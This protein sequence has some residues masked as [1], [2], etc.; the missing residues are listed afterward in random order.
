MYFD[1]H[2]CEILLSEKG[3]C[4]CQMGEFAQI[5]P[6]AAGRE[7]VIGRKRGFSSKQD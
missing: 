3:F 7:G 5:G 4:T 1:N 2:S 6:C